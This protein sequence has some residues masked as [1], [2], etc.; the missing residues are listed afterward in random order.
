M[1]KQT[2]L[3]IDD[4]QPL[5]EDVVKLMNMEGYKGVGAKDGAEGI[6]LALQL[7]PDLIVC[8][9][10]MPKMNGLE[11]IKSIRQI[12]GY[13]SIPF[14]FL[15]A[16]A[17]PDDF[18]TGLKLGADDYITK[19]FELDELLLSVSQKLEKYENLVRKNES[20]FLA[21]AENP[22]I[23]IFIYTQNNIIYSNKYFEDISGYSSHDI[24]QLNIEDIVISDKEKFI[25][26]L[27]FCISGLHQDFRTDI[28]ILSKDRK[29]RILSFY[30]KHIDISGS[31]AVVC[32]VY[33][34]EPS[35]SSDKHSKTPG[36]ITEIESIIEKLIL[37]DKNEIVTEIE[38]VLQIVDF[39]KENRRND[40]IK[41][42]NISERET[43]I[44]ELV[45][46][47]LTNPQI[48]EKL[49]ISPRTVDN[50][51]AALLAKTETANTAALVAYAVSNQLV[52]LKKI[53][54]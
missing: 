23:G 19:P 54:N 28:S 41:K 9:I 27:N 10:E 46:R 48:A 7:K 40:I 22:F 11:V 35:A 45:C 20:K 17:Q 44:L 38:A 3:V 43:E 16:R 24:K 4:Y 1:K 30:A 37:L 39:D 21:L 42:C 25:R 14:I 51:R 53:T 29:A 12:A 2:I 13:E 31:N 18:R 50:H 52:D 34:N 33:V 26:E 5:L 6:Q 15:T 32:T 47:G 49:F 8:D 36:Q